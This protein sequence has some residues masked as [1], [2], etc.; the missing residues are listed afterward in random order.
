MGKYLIKM[1]Y[2]GGE[3][4][5]K[6]FLLRKGGYVSSYNALDAGWWL[7]DETY[8]TEAIARRRCKQL[9][10]ERRYQVARGFAE[11]AIFEP[12]EVR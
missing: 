10:E 5:G 3:H 8:K 2:V 12:I 7:P 6:T 11:N 9:E 1:T 4:E